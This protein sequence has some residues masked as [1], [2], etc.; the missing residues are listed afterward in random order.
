MLVILGAVT[1]FSEKVDFSENAN[2]YLT[3]FPSLTTR[4]YFTGSY[5]DDIDD[6][7]SDH[8]ALHDTLIRIKS[9]FELYLG[10]TEQN[11]VYILSDRIV[12][13]VEDPDEAALSKNLTGIIT[14]AE[15]H[16]MPVYMMLVPTS[17][18]I[19]A[20]E[21]PNNAQNLDQRAFM[22]TVKDTLGNSVDFI[23]VYTALMSEKDSYIFYRTDH[24]WTTY[25]AYI[26][27]VAAARKMG[28]E[29]LSES[30]FDIEHASD[31]FN[32]TFYS[33][34][35]YEGITSDSIDLWHLTD[36]E[37]DITVEI[38]S[39]FDEEPI[40]YDSIYFR[41]YLSVKDKYSVFLGTNQPLVTI[42]TGSSGG[43]LLI[44]KDS[45]ANSY[46]PYLLSHYSEITLVDLRY[47]QISINDVIDVDSYDS[48]LILYNVS[49]FIDDENLKKLSW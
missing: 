18:E 35:L 24:H 19:Y 3:S 42:K 36:V 8:F 40:V 46:I 32:G 47:I 37:N 30:A 10:K 38:Y 14:F 21:L 29:A 45:Y 41:D 48:T 31:N 26:S 28:Y 2:K 16:D 1:F 22:D 44:F 17:A 43:K 11:G 33:K 25:G 15:S 6:Y 27:Y 23:D 5:T 9:T 49:G 12:E 20:D 13:H 39:S 4:T 34:V 7:V